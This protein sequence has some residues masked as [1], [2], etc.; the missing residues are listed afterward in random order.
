MADGINPASTSWSG[1]AAI[2]LTLVL[3]G[4]IPIF[5]KIGLKGQ[6]AS[7]LAGMV[8]RVAAAI[9]LFL[10][11]LVFSPSVRA[12][13]AGLSWRAVLV[14]ALSGVISLVLAQY[15]YYSALAQ[16]DVGRLFPV[17]FGGAPVVGIL[18]A[19]LFLGESLSL[20]TAIGA[21]LIAAGSVLL[22]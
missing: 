5:D 3:W 17:L 20:K 2:A 9:L 7:P 12:D 14:F 18:F 4:L 6:T 21:L 8:V 19:A 13:I 16:R 15:L 11:W 10:P 1:A 22:L